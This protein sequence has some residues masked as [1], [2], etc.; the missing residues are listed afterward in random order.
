[1]DAVCQLNLVL[2]YL[3]PNVGVYLQIFQRIFIAIVPTKVQSRNTVSKEAGDFWVC[4]G[5]TA[6]YNDISRNLR[7]GEIRMLDLACSPKSVWRP[8]LLD[9]RLECR[10]GK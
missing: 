7:N 1:M 5:Q 10:N 8:R 9:V 6:K 2:C 3:F 4:I